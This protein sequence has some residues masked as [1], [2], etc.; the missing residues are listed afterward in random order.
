MYNNF[1]D[2]IQKYPNIKNIIDNYLPQNI[3]EVDLDVNYISWKIGNP[4]NYNK[5]YIGS[6]QLDVAINNGTSNMEYIFDK[7]IPQKIVKNIESFVPTTVSVPLEFDNQTI[8]GLQIQNNLIEYENYKFNVYIGIETDSDDTLLKNNGNELFNDCQLLALNGK[9]P[10]TFKDTLPT[11]FGISKIGTDPV[12]GEFGIEDLIKDI[13][14]RKHELSYKVGNLLKLDINES[15]KICQIATN[16]DLDD[17]IIIT[18]HNPISNS[19]YT[20]SKF[21]FNYLLIVPIYSIPELEMDNL[22][23]DIKKEIIRQNL[24]TLI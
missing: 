11:V 10:G 1:T 15:S 6:S 19:Y 23:V 17:T 4:D 2:L 12:S 16:A 22:I 21:K 13:I 3:P 7:K 20:P 9:A 24:K 8:I 5:I 18:T 14:I